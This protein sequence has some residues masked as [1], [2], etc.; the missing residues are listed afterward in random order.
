MSSIT[1]A[2]SVAMMSSTCA[3]VSRKSSGDQL[4]NRAEYA[5]TASSPRARMSAMT[6]VTVSLTPARS[7]ATCAAGTASF[8]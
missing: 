1:C 4:S 5:R 3:A 8:R 7:A 6:A 2:G